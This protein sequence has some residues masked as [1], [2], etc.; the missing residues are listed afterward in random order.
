MSRIE[1]MSKKQR[2][3]E[4][5]APVSTGGLLRCSKHRTPLKC[6]AGRNAHWINWY[7]PE[8]DKDKAIDSLRGER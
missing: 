5:G 8:C 3:V 7:C 6:F 2:A 1:E 4:K